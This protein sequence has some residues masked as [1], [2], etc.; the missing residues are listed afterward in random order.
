MLVQCSHVLYGD[1]F[2]IPRLRTLLVRSLNSVS[3]HFLLV[4]NIEGVE[5]QAWNMEHVRTLMRSEKKSTWCYHY[6]SRVWDLS[7]CMSIKLVRV[8]FWMC[9][10]EF[11]LSLVVVVSH[12]LTTEQ[13]L[14]AH[15][16]WSG[17]YLFMCK[18]F[19]I[20]EYLIYLKSSI[21]TWHHLLSTY[22]M[23]NSI[24]F[25]S[26]VLLFQDPFFNKIIV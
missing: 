11:D 1:W 20:A 10:L 7:L 3:E 13:K 2:G 15:C 9:V 21:S 23:A 25:Q 16:T 17:L 24:F 14:F 26:S 5:C 8:F 19:L 6:I 18:V 22:F 12:F 4:L